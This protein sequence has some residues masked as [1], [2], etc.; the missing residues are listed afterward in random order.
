MLNICRIWTSLAT[1][2]AL[3]QNPARTCSEVI[4]EGKSEPDFLAARALWA[5]PSKLIQLV[6]NPKQTQN[7]KMINE[8]LQTLITID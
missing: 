2:A 8:E 5:I 1:T 6:N 7:E 4:P 3:L